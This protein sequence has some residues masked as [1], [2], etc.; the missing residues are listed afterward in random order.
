MSNVATMLSPG[1]T[2][3]EFP[4]CSPAKLPDEV[5]QS[6]R[7]LILRDLV[8]DWPLVKAA[9]QSADMADEY[10]RRFYNSRPVRASVGP[11]E[12]GG[13]IFY[14][15]DLSELNFKTV[16]TQLDEFLDSLKHHRDSPRPPA[17]Y[18][19][20]V[21]VDSILPGMRS[22]NDLDLVHLDPS[23]RIWIGNQTRIAAHYDFTYNIAC[24]A[25][26][27]RRFTLFPPEQ[28][29]NLYIGPLDFTPAGQSISLVDFNKPDFEKYPKFREALPHAQVADLKPGDA[30]FIPGMWW[31]HVESLDSFNVLINYWWRST[32]AYLG[33]PLDALNHALLS[34]R[35]LPAAQREIWRGI[36]DHYVF[37]PDEDV[38]AHIPEDRRGV[39][40]PIDE[41][42]ARKLRALLLKRLNR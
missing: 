26:G 13:R 34:I 37:V 15:E 12:I 32:P 8:A 33:T 2:I 30:I 20:S 3:T 7:P 28:L 16:R 39:L 21:D 23:V 36:F 10:L 25:A 40:A 38:A 17:H 27:S 19:G 31:H 1:Q 9:R 35:D 14:T 41:P 24:V 5:V 29:E 22:E 11:P 42:S 18:V 6:E 4:G